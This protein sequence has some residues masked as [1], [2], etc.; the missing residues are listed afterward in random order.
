MYFTVAPKVRRPPMRRLSLG[1]S[2]E[3]P[4]ARRP[5]AQFLRGRLLQ[6]EPDLEGHLEMADRAVGDVPADLGDLEPVQLAP[7]RSGPADP[8]ADGLPARVRRGPADRGAPAGVVH[9]RP[10]SPV[11]APPARFLPPAPPLHDTN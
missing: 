2:N 8:V 6:L 5:P 1:T 10:L 9:L 7:R 3:H 4:S 11:S